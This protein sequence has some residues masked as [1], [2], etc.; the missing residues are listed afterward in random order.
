MMYR[1]NFPT[2]LHF[3][4]MLQILVCKQIFVQNMHKNHNQSH[5]RTIMWSIMKTLILLNPKENIILFGSIH[6]N[7]GISIQFKFN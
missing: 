1:Y 7:L 4:I 3:N 5:S 6:F 2:K